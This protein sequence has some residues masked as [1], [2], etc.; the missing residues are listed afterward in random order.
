MSSDF[1]SKPSHVDG[2]AQQNLA[3]VKASIEYRIASRSFSIFETLKDRTHSFV[4]SKPTSVLFIFGCQR[5]GT[6]H[7]ERLFRADPRSVVFGEFSELSVQPNKTVWAPIAQLEKRLHA[8]RGAYA[9]ARSLL[10]SHRAAEIVDAFPSSHAVWMYRAA[11]PVV[12][13]MWVKWRDMFKEISR[14]V[15]T[16]LSGN[17]D[18]APLWKHLERDM[19]TL[20]SASP[21]TEAWWRD[22]YGLY[23]H[24][25]NAAYFDLELFVDSRISLLGYESL[26]DHPKGNVD[27]FTQAVG[28]EPARVRFP[29]KTRTS[30]SSNPPAESFS[31]KIQ[32]MCDAL[33]ARLQ[34]AEEQGQ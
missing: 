14:R 21:D 25:R 27:S 31:P 16:D 26:Q 19:T 9:V 18:L 20:S 28:I 6:T 12:N 2:R 13:S 33:H 23:W 8:G 1:S 15:E 34:V 11:G 5:S 32:D 10:A 30:K 7:L 22:L 4:G 17:W 24:A 3:R 29:L